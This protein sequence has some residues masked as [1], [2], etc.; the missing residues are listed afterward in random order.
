MADATV[1]ADLN[2]AFDI[3]IDFA[4]KIALDL[5]LTVDQLAKAINLFL[6]QIF[7][8][9]IRINACSLKD[10]AARRQP[11]PINVAQ[12]NFHALFAWDINAGDSSHVFL[13]LRI[14]RFNTALKREEEGLKRIRPTSPVFAYVLDL[15]YRSPLPHDGGGS[16]CSYRNA[17]L[18]RRALS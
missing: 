2:Q 15:C 12:R 8:S 7:H 10:L 13:Q 6:G 3:Q 17:V 14:T 16:P 9:R 4:T 11:D 18:L 1:A 5:I